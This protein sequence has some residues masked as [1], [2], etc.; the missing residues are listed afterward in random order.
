MAEY[1]GRKW[2]PPGEGWQ[3]ESAFG[4][5]E[6]RTAAPVWTAEQLG[7]AAAQLRAPQRVDH[8]GL[9]PLA[10][11]AAAAAVPAAVCSAFGLLASCAEGMRAQAVVAHAFGKK[12]SCPSLDRVRAIMPLSTVSGVMDVV[13]ASAI[14]EELDAMPAL[15]VAVC[16]G[17][18][19]GASAGDLAWAARMTVEKTLDRGS[20]GAIAQ[21]DVQQ[22]YD[23]LPVGECCAHLL[24]AGL[25]ME[26]RRL[27]N[28]IR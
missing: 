18:R 4:T 23:H 2:S 3:G 1:F 9:A 26:W 15:H 21:G 5:A 12:S 25:P 6:R 10:V 14:D 7:R 19:P 22:F 28:G 13:R 17:A 8:K 20:R 16:E 24:R 11:V 27:H